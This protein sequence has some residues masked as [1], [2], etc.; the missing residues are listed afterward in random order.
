MELRQCKNHGETKHFPRKGT[1]S[2]RCGKCS[3]EQ[4]GRRRRKVKAVLVAEAGGSCRV[5]GYD[6]YQGSLEFHHLD[7]S[8]KKFGLASGG[9][10]PAIAKLREE[11]KKCLLLCRN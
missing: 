8:T 2:W 9:F 7:P 5:C 3:S 10:T 4:V 6:R 1:N 11:A